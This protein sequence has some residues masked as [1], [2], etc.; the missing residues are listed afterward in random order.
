MCRSIKTLHNFEP[1]ATE[2]EIRAS[3]LQF[4]R[5]LSGFARPSKA[6][7]H[8]FNLAVDQVAL[9]AHTL[10]AS[11]TTNGP[12][13]D[14]EIEASKAKGQEREPLQRCAPVY[15]TAAVAFAA[16]LGR[17]PPLAAEATRAAPILHGAPPFRR[18]RR[19]SLGPRKPLDPPAAPLAAVPPAF[20]NG[21]FNRRARAS[22]TRHGAN[23]RGDRRSHGSS[24][25]DR[26]QDRAS[27]GR[28]QHLHGLT[29]R[30]G[31][32]RRQSIAKARRK[33]GVDRQ[34]TQK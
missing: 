28:H 21:P 29:P 6:N 10:L 24:G 22:L 18:S 34:R 9:A 14:R 23:G 5:K 15:V 8:A 20:E 17:S 19:I 30:G 13:R 27:C 33:V 25:Q 7:E 1:P 2:D 4:V 16:E 12:P 32:V 31:W 11:L 3:S 26:K